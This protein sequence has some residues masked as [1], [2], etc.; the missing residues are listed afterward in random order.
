[1]QIVTE[2]DTTSSGEET[3][4]KVYLD[5]N[6]LSD[7]PRAD[8]EINP[9]L[10]TLPLKEAILYGPLSCFIVTGY[11]GVGKTSFINYIREKSRKEFSDVIQNNPSHE[12]K[13][14]LFVNCNFVN[15]DKKE[16]ILRK[17]VR[18][19]VTSAQEDEKASKILDTKPDLRDELK[20]LYKRTFA[21]VNDMTKET[22]T[23]TTTISKASNLSNT[24]IIM[25]IISLA[26]VS[27]VIWNLIL[28]FDLKYATGVMAII[29]ILTTVYT[30]QR[31]S[32]TE[33]KSHKEIEVKTLYDDEIAETRLIGYIQR[34]R[35]LGIK[36]I[37]T[38]DE[39]DKI[40]N[41]D[42]L[43]TFISELKPILISGK[44][45]FILIAGQNLYYRLKKTLSV[46]DAVLPSIVADTYH[47]PFPKAEHLRQL[48][49]D[50]VYL[51][52]GD[53]NVY[54]HYLDS[55]ILKAK[56]NP[57]KFI[58][59]LRNKVKWDKTMSP[60]KPYIEISSKNAKAFER[61]SNILECIERMA[62]NLET[63]ERDLE[64]PSSQRDF[65]ISQLHIVAEEIKA[66]GISPFQLEDLLTLDEHIKSQLPKS[67]IDEL[68]S[69]IGKFL[70][71]MKGNGILSQDDDT[72]NY[73]LKELII[74]ENTLELAI[75][76]FKKDMLQFE[77]FICGI[78]SELFK[79]NENT[80]YNTIKRLFDMEII[81]DPTVFK[82][83]HVMSVQDKCYSRNNSAT[84]EEVSDAERNIMFLKLII[85]KNYTY[86][87]LQETLN[88][89]NYDVK[90]NIQ[91]SIRNRLDIV[92]KITNNN[93]S[94]GNI[95]FEIKIGEIND[96][97]AN[98]LVEQVQNY[99]THLE[100]SN[101]Y[102]CKL[103]IILFTSKIS[104]VQRKLLDTKFFHTALN[105]NIP[106][107]IITPSIYR[108][109]DK[110]LDQ[111]LLEV[112]SKY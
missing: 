103:I 36:V 79:R 2:P 43:D 67:Y 73:N 110:S 66:K 71:I 24:F 6:F 89:N 50:N 3:E 95:I 17:L 20:V 83:Q 51:N 26:L 92:A 53:N 80:F 61:D 18:Q 49:S 33:N 47:I 64:H 19:L 74:E 77:R 87:V 62:S 23:D 35:E 106:I 76:N 14:L 99:I 40:E 37:F 82:I 111:Y 15:G 85:I 7:A 56:R 97:T 46:D 75:K 109:S 84:L 16:H 44:A 101:L 4:V 69:I 78:H 31:N 100:G 13:S 34:L 60:P 68:N 22:D 107:D 65:L 27:N 12:Y 39:L 52:E 41:D 5:P 63:G 30:Y 91:F 48:F 21:Q 11:R 104:Q 9:L 54:K 70:D 8:V 81:D 32:I 88:Q 90:E 96:S 86:Y 94:T 58:N 105:S 45:A 55:I 108:D 28:S 112:I 25:S 57:R 98:N 1:M 38:L 10:E 93:I 102:P 59:T 42:Q 29:S 72:F